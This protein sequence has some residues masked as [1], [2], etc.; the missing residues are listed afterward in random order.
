MASPTPFDPS[1]FRM[2]APPSPAPPAAVPLPTIPGLRPA[3]EP[4]PVAPAPEPP[5]LP[6]ASDATVSE[7]LRVAEEGGT[8]IPR[9]E[10]EIPAPG[11]VGLSRSGSVDTTHCP[12]CGW[13][14]S[15]P[16]TIE[17]ETGDAHA[18]LAMILG[19]K[20]V[21]FFKDIAIFGGQVRLQLRSLTSTEGD[22]AWAQT[23]DDLKAGRL[24]N[25]A[26]VVR[27]VSE[28]RMT[29]ALSR[30]EMGGAPPISIPEVSHYQAPPGVRTP[31][32]MLRDWIFAEVLPSEA[33][34][35]AV[36]ERYAKFQS[37]CEKLEARASDPDFWTGIAAQP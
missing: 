8:S 33:L 21:R 37:L 34:R 11:E 7:A 16:D 20:G 14:Q 32:P 17:P 19:G 25:D 15:L 12:H 31:L 24:M 4:L 2:K 30:L 35:R 22:L 27:Q 6:G 10:A 36:F 23:Y 3:V 18:Y 29:M 13:D 1:V 26:E 5:L 28:Y 9:N